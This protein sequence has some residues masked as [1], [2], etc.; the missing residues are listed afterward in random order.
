MRILI[1]EDY[2]DL[3][4]TL[5]ALPNQVLVVWGTPD[6]VIPVVHDQEANRARQSRL[7]VFADCGHCHH[8]ERSDAFNQLVTLR[9]D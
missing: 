1:A 5:A 2:P 3:R 7:E 6:G 4:E 9:R 8:I